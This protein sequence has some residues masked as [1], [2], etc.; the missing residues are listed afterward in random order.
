MA[1]LNLPDSGTV[2]LDTSGFIYSVERVEPY[3]T[4][5]EPMWHR[6]RDGQFVVV[7]SEL[8]V[9][10]TLVKPIRDENSAAETLFRSLFEAKELS[11]IPVS[12]SILEIAAGIRAD[13]G[14]KA[15]DAIHVATAVQEGCSV[16]LTNDGDLRRVRNLPVVMLDEVARECS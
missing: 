12:R 9:L 14:L 16:F 13:V 1:T 2:Y 7:T 11:L 6:A 4:L 3:R 15:P 5:L 8:T 10:E